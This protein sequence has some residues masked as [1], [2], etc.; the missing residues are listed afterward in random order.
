MISMF[1]AIVDVFGNFSGGTSSG[2]GPESIRTGI[3]GNLTTDLQGLTS[4]RNNGYGALPRR[5]RLLC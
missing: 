1:T 5:S 4:T 3:F 2:G